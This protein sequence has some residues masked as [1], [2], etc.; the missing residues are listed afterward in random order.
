MDFLTFR[1]PVVSHF[2]REREAEWHWDGKQT[3]SVGEGISKMA[4]KFRTSI[5]TAHL[6]FLD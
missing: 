4:Q 6:A 3:S 2:V 5:K 1:W